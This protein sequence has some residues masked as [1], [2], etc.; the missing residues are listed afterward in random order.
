MLKKIAVAIVHGMGNQ[1]EEFAK[2]SIEMIK[3]EF[4]RNLEQIIANPSS[5]L[6]IEPMFWAEIFA[7]R[8]KEL[9]RKLHANHNLNFH[10][11]RKFVIHYLGDAVAYQPVETNQHNY[12]RVHKKIENGL[13]SL[14]MKA[15]NN[16]PLCVISHSLGAVISSNYFYDL[17]YKEQLVDSGSRDRSP[18][19]QGDTLT[20]FYTLGTTL[21]LWSLRYHDFDRPINIPSPKLNE[22][23]PGLSGEW[24]NFF[25]KEDIL[26][27]PLREVD[28]SYENAV[29]EDKEVNVG[30]ILTNWNPFSHSAYLTDENV[31]ETIVKGLVRT[32][33]QINNL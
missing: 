12:E 22:Y 30:N 8:E 33:R 32:W 1:T 10:D 26:G 25:D 5:F 21:P 31:I 19:E 18:L 16:A 7:E 14:S 17:Q 20:L 23:Y 2:D 9:F 24:I 4:N 28:K 6:I 15:G 29:K 3:R 27:Y 11:L 13:Q